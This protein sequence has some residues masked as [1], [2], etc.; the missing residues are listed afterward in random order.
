MPPVHRRVS[1]ALALALAL[2]LGAGLTTGAAAGESALPPEEQTVDGV[3]PR[4]D[5]EASELARLRLRSI[6]EEE[7]QRT[8]AAST[9]ALD[10]LN[11]VVDRVPGRDRY[12][13]AA[14][15]STFWGEYVWD[16]TW[17]SGYDKIVFLASGENFADALSGGAVAGSDA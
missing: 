4:L 6:P 11:P 1:A 17:P 5:R 9:D 14:L 13:V 15:L 16:E 2:P 3:I 12:A 7:V 8:L 10:I